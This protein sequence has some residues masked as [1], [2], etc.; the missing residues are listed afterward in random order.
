MTNAEHPTQA[1]APLHK[2]A[3]FSRAVLRAAGADAATAEA[4]TRAML[5]ASRLGVDSHGIRLLAHYVTVIEAGRVNGAPDMHFVGHGGAVASLEADNAHGARATYHAMDKAMELAERFGMG[6]VSIRHSSHF[7]AAGAY[8]LAAA[9]AGFIGLAVCNSDSFVRLHDGAMR[10]HGTN[11]IAFGVPVA[12]SQ[13]WLLDMAT[14]AIPYNRV[15][16]YESLG[17]PLPVGV[18]S[19]TDG[20]DTT[21]P[22]EADMLAPVGGAFGF[23]GAALAGVVEILSAVLSGMKLSFDILPMG[24]PDLSTPRGLGAFVMAIKPGAF[25][26]EATFEAGMHHYLQ[27]LRASPVRADASLDTHVMAPGDREW[28]V[29]QARERDGI[30]LDPVTR[31]AFETFSQTFGVPLPYAG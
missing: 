30:P 17:Q 9:E 27:Q 13:P 20:T 14:S 4:A 26:D 5:H 2:V 8:A 10:F 7:G 21:I 15:K 1:L 31:A 23:K 29:A 19:K 16:L 22:E 11:P 6:A 12:G 28:K 3:D 25:I 18:A 24:G